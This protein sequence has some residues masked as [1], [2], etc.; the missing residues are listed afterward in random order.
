MNEQSL[1]NRSFLLQ[2]FWV[3]VLVCPCYM[4]Q[5]HLEQ[6]LQLLKLDF[7]AVRVTLVARTCRLFGLGLSPLLPLSRFDDQLSLEALPYLKHL[8]LCWQIILCIA[9][10]EFI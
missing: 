9:L 10:L 4:C 8:L 3:D 5:H 1:G 2:L 7:I 6:S